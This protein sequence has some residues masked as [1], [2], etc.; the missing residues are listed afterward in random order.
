M[1]GFPDLVEGS[2]K[3]LQTVDADLKV[4]STLWDHIDDVTGQLNEFLGCKWKEVDND[5]MEDYIKNAKKTLTSKIKGQ[6]RKT[7][8]Y[9]DFTKHLKTW[10]TFNEL[11]MELI[12]ESMIV[13]DDRHWL[14]IRE[15]LNS[16][17]V[18][19]P[20]SELD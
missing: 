1:F 2:E 9:Q 7:D 11:I 6:T 10:T 8:A 5:A 15:I 13:D 4:I 12:H 14:K 3:T 17:I 16:E 20:D 18:M 19:L